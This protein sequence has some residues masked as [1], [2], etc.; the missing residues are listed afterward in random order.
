MNFCRRCGHKFK[1]NNN[2]IFTCNNGHV[3]YAN[4]SPATAAILINDQDEILVVERTQQPGKG[5]YD[6]PGGFCN[7]AETAEDALMRE[8]N[9]ELGLTQDQYSP[10]TFVCSEI[11]P[12]VLDGETIPALSMVFYA[13]LIKPFVLQPM[14]DVVNPSFVPLHTFDPSQLYFYSLQKAVTQYKSSMNMSS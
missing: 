14:D 6:L 5:C 4:A 10:F 1:K 13:H 3:I 8:I 9:E 2:H 11:D 12:Y 7:G